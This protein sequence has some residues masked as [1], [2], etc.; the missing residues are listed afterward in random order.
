VVSLTA[1]D[2]H[3]LDLEIERLSG[4]RRTSRMMI[5]K[6]KWL[7]ELFAGHWRHFVIP[8]PLT[9]MPRHFAGPDHSGIYFLWDGSDECT[10]VGRSNC[11]GRR[12]AEHHIE[13]VK[14]F[15][16]FATIACP[17]AFSDMVEDAYVE[18]VAPAE[19]GFL[20]S[21]AWDGHRAMVDAI[22]AAWNIV[23]DE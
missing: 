14:R 6:P 3:A 12:L 1:P 5:H 4:G 18:A 16:H 22:T 20:R 7:R 23:E 10:Y 9:I 19:N 13:R 21:P 17:E 8:L 15:T 2:L 11:V